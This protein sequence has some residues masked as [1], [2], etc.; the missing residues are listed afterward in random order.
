M[1]AVSWKYAMTR[2]ANLIYTRHGRLWTFQA[3]GDDFREHY[4]KGHEVHK[5]LDPAVPLNYGNR[6]AVGYVHY[7]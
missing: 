1:Q 5:L 2:I 3:S 7:L 6:E 4:R